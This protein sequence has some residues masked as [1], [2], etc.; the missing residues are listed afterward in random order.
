MRMAP[1]PDELALWRSFLAT[2]GGSWFALAD[3]FRDEQLDDLA[4]AVPLVKTRRPAR[5][6]PRV[7]GSYY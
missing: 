6:N 2:D 3:W 4:D 1:T 5:V 7:E